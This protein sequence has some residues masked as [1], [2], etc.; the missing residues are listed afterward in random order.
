MNYV[1]QKSNRIYKVLLFYWVI[2]VI[3][4]NLRHTV[5]R[6]GIDLVVKAALI[7]WLLVEFLWVEHTFSKKSFILYSTF[8]TFML[9]VFVFIENTF[10]FSTILN[11]VYPLLMVFLI[12]VIGNSFTINIHEL[13]YMCNG[14]IIVVAYTTIYGLIVH[15]NQFVEAVTTKMAYGSELKSFFVSSHEYGL[16]LAGGI[17]C[18]LIALKIKSRAEVRDK[19]YYWIALALFIPSMILTYSRTT[20]LG[21][22]C[23]FVVLVIFSKNNGV[24]KALIIG[25][26]IVALLIIFVE[27]IRTYVFNNILKQNKLGAR[28]EIYNVAFE[29]FKRGSLNHIL[30]GHGIE[31][32][33]AFTVEETTH[34]SVHNAYLQI[35]LYYGVVGLTFLAAFFVIQIIGTIKLLKKNNFCGAM[36]LAVQIMGIAVMF[37]NTAYVFFPSTDSYFLTLVSIIVPKY[38]RN[39]INDGVFYVES[40]KDVEPYWYDISAYQGGITE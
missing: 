34:T 40:G 25:G 9:L 28:E 3:W 23:V 10:E 4:Q 6:S 2:L 14:T 39:A 5:S 36:M 18:S 16:Y 31:A 22:V 26:I 33:R 7:V 15:T 20:M 21:I 27:P 24:K 19:F 1:K 8:F 11:Y 17:I 38:V 37:T 35:L 12:C 30:F 32:S 13:L 29:Y